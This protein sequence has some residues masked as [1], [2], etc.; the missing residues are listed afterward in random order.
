MKL[1]TIGSG[2]FG[3]IF[4]VKNIKTGNI[5]AIKE[6]D[7]SKYKSLTKKEL[8]ENI[9]TKLNLENNNI[10]IKE[11]IDSNN[12]LYFI[13]EYCPLNLEDYL[14]I[15]ENNLSIDEI[16][17][18]LKQ[19]NNI[20]EKINE[21]NLTIRDIKVSN[22]LITLNTLPNITIKTSDYD[23]SQYLYDNKDLS[24]SLTMSPEVL[25]GE[26]NLEKNNIWVLGNLIYYMIFKEYLYNGKNL[27]QLLTS[28]KK[29]KKPKSTQDKDLT[30]LLLKML[31]V[32]ISK[33]IS[34]K[35]YLNHPFFKK[36]NKTQSN[37][38]NIQIPNLFNFTCINHSKQYEFFCASCN[39]NICKSCLVKHPINSHKIIPFAKIGF[40][41]TEVEQIEDLLNDLEINMN[42]LRK[43]KN[44]TELFLNKMKS[45]NGN[46]SIYKNEELNYKNYF[47]QYL[48][49]INSNLGIT[50]S[51]KIPKFISDN[52]NINNFIICEHVI[53]QNQVGKQIQILNF[54]SSSLISMI[55]FGEE[56]KNEISQDC[57]IYIN[58]KKI[59][60]TFKYKFL[61]E[62]KFTIKFEYKNPLSNL[63]CMFQNCETLKL[64]DFSNFITE[65]I[66][67]MIGTFTKCSSL[68]NLDI[69]KIN[70]N[71]IKNLS[72]LFS[73]CSSLLSLDLSSFNTENV[74]NIEKMFKNCTSL[75]SLDLSN[76]NTKNITS[77]DSLFEN[78][79]SLSSLNLSK[80]NTE[81][82]INMKNMFKKCSSLKNLD[83]SNFNTIHVTDMS[84]MFAE[85][86]SLNSIN[87]KNFNTEN[88]VDLSSM[89]YDCSS[90]NSINLSHFKTDN[91]I[92]VKNMFCG[93]RQLKELNISKFNIINVSDISNMFKNCSSL[94]ELDL[95]NF[96]TENVLEMNNLFE[97]C[98]S[99]K[100]LNL[101][102]LI[103]KM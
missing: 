13:M 57:N 82:V 67:S 41:S 46:N 26:K 23:L 102:N 27:N 21:S 60:F 34:F 47:I 30:D 83:L 51:I 94:I 93:C 15:R 45:I 64:I 8:N 58:N 38:K 25:K 14:K 95:S 101:S 92:D 73:G 87:L 96:N 29:G 42:K 75:N 4:K 12:F 22:L 44:D 36:D 80:L 33:R 69:S 78:C 28:I 37:L 50:D 17:Q 53:N 81:N 72:F 10:R 43:L 19:I 79:S 39:C 6:I 100:K 1:E 49:I 84:F 55:G 66:T 63:N 89:F 76:F 86:N 103:L 2:N 7:K 68:T 70:S 88:V 9:I 54:M 91:L 59:D 52:S 16:R 99:L 65:N 11:T 5:Y 24:I 61:R 18:M 3:K 20:F 31:D 48:Q 98:D 77:M 35:D 90:L 40:I 56:N 74:I 97:G 85:C 62:G 71:K 32:D